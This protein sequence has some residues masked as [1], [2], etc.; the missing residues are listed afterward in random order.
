MEIALGGHMTWREGQIT[1]I[2]GGRF[3]LGG[4]I[5]GLVRG[6]VLGGNLGGERI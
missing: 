2:A 6:F 3:M 5:G 4:E 1:K